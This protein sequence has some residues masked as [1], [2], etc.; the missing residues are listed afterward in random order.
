[1]K[2]EFESLKD[3]FAIVY[4]MLTNKGK[5]IRFGLLIPLDLYRFRLY[6]LILQIYITEDFILAVYLFLQI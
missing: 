5:N 2:E 6:I 1:M 3:S 4:R